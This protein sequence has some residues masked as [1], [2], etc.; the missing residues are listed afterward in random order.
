MDEMAAPLKARRF[1]QAPGSLTALHQMSLRDR[2]RGNILGAGT[3][4]SSTLAL[5]YG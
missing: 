1:A 2:Q 5:R 3:P 4:F